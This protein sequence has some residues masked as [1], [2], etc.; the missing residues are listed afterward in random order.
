MG[1]EGGGP[2]KNG[3][4][5]GGGRGG[6]TKNPKINKGRGD[7]YLEPKSRLE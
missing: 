2:N 3:G 6:P 1:R 7:Y 5:W 4:G